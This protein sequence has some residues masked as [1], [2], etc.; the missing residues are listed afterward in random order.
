MLFKVA[1]KLFRVAFIV[2]N[3]LIYCN[4]KKERAFDSAKEELRKVKEL[5]RRHRRF[6]G[7]F[8]PSRCRN[9]RRSSDSSYNSNDSNNRSSSSNNRINISNSRRISNS[10]IR[11][12]HQRPSMN[13]SCSI[14]SNNEL[15]PVKTKLS[16]NTENISKNDIGNPVIITPILS[17]EAKARRMAYIDK[18]VLIAQKAAEREELETKKVKNTSEA[19]ISKEVI[20]AVPAEKYN[21][22]LSDVEASLKTQGVQC[23]STPSS[24]LITESSAT[25]NTTGASSLT[26]ASSVEENKRV[27]DSSDTELDKEI[28]DVDSIEKSNEI[29]AVTSVEIKDE[30]STTVQKEVTVTTTPTITTTIPAITTVTPTITVITPIITTTN[31]TINTT[32]P[33]IT[34]TNP[35]IHA[36]T[37]TNPTI[38][39]TIP[40]TQKEDITSGTQKEGNEKTPQKGTDGLGHQKGNITEATLGEVTGTKFQEMNVVL[41]PK[42]DLCAFCKEAYA[43]IS[44]CSD[45][46][47]SS[48]KIINTI[49]RN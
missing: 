23:S 2:A 27:P 5:T 20:V 12:L 24:S 47:S 6:F 40:K 32:I 22:S 15:P 14:K 42:K 48:V 21:P 39:T 31:P 37:T 13:G 3:P 45:K 16:N 8:R 1:R 17:A 4:G 28:V 38:T 25:E 46:V 36:I 10:S 33:T 29:L 30:D 43:D 49:R 35:T 19:P 34:N 7:R 11:S 18:T 41:S 26:T 9:S 44:S